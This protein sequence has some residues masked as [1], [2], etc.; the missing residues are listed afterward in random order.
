VMQQQKGKEK[1][2]DQERFMKEAAGTSGFRQ[3][4]GTGA[5]FRATEIERTTSRHIGFSAS[6]L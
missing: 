4:F 1:L 5:G 6:C 3:S 2:T